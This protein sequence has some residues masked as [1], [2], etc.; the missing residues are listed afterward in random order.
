VEP[1]TP[2]HFFRKSGVTRTLVTLGLVH[3]KDR[4]STTLQICKTDCYYY[5]H[6]TSKKSSASFSCPHREPNV[7]LPSPS[8]IMTSHPL[9]HNSACTDAEGAARGGPSIFCP[10]LL[11][12][13]LFEGS[14]ARVTPDPAPAFHDAPAAV[15]A[16]VTSSCMPRRCRSTRHYWHGALDRNRGVRFNMCVRQCKF[17]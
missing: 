5:R 14:V 12:V 15:A 7:S 16:R 13:R 9:A 3:P 8:L 1:R 2:S 11:P 6:Q 4:I 17:A 10:P